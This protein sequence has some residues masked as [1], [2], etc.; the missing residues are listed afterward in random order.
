MINIPDFDRVLGQD[1]GP[2]A[3]LL[4]LVAVPGGTHRFDHS[5]GVFM[6][7]KR[8]ERRSRDLHFGVTNVNFLGFLVI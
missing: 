1:G 5:F 8:A 2:E 7:L 4:N 6:A 3:V